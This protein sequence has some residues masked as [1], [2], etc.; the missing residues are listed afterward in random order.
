ALAPLVRV[1][2]ARECDR[3]TVAARVTELRAA[4]E[5]ASNEWGAAKGAEE[6]ALAAREERKGAL[7]ARAAE[8]EG[9][10]RPAT[11]LRQHGGGL[12]MAARA[13]GKP[14]DE[15]RLAETVALTA[16]LGELKQLERAA[17]SA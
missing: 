9:A 5:R 12:Q 11:L 3:A 16:Q 17:A 10:S 4:A 8:L 1:H 6:R 7:V 14:F 2:R 13:D 15:E